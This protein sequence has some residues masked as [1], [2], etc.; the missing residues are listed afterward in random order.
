MLNRKKDNKD[1]KYSQAVSNILDMK[2][3]EDLERMKKIRAH[4]GLRHYCACHARSPLLLPS[5]TRMGRCAPRHVA[6]ARTACPLLTGGA[7]FVDH[8]GSARAWP[9]HKDHGPQG[10]HRRCRQ[11]KGLGERPQFLRRGRGEG[12]SRRAG[13]RCRRSHTLT[14]L[15]SF[16]PS[17]F[18]H[19]ACYAS[20]RG[21]APSLV[22]CDLVGF[23][24]CIILF[25][26]LSAHDLLSSA[27][28]STVW[29]LIV[30]V[31]VLEPDKERESQ[32]GTLI[33]H[34]DTPQSI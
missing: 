5:R 30:P 24:L 10:P 16:Q 18:S 31:I 20:E 8:R 32:R 27:E 34:L 29:D 15:R 11:E 14:A 28:P 6:A 7:S 12:V 3:R 23:A 9:A 22:V 4:R 19:A 25:S 17:A 13:E 1:G 33:T 2:Y 21:G 26:V